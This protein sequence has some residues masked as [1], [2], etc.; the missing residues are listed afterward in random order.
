MVNGFSHMRRSSILV[1]LSV[2]ILLCTLAY[3]YLYPGSLALFEGR[4]DT[5]MSDGTDPTGLSYVYDLIIDLWRT[6]PARY[7]YGALFTNV[8]DPEYGNIL[9]M[10]LSERW[11]VLLHSNFFALEQL[12]TAYVYTLLVLNGL[13]MFALSLYMGWSQWIATGLAIAWAFNTFTMARA[14]VHM[15]M[16]GI[17]H[18]PLIFL[19]LMMVVRGK[20]K[21]SL[22]WASLALL[23]A[24]TTVHYF[25][26]ISLFLSPFFVLFVLIQPEF[27]SDW[28]RIGKRFTIAVVPVLLLLGMNYF[29]ALPPETRMT[30]S[31]SMTLDVIPDGRTHPYLRTYSA[32]PI[33]YL[34]GNLFG[35]DGSE[36]N[37]LRT[38]I[39]DHILGNLEDSNSHERTNGIRWSV[40]ALGLCAFACLFMGK[41]KEQKVVS[42]NL[43]YFFIFGLFAFWL[44][45]SP[46]VPF[47]ETGPSYWLHR[48]MPKV[49]VLNRAGVYVH[50]ALLMAVGFLLS[51]KFKWRKLLAAFPL[52][53]VVDYTP[54]MAMPM[55]PIYP[56]YEALQREKGECGVG[57]QIPF[58]NPYS[59]PL[60]SYLFSQRLR[61]SDCL[62]LNI[63][64]SKDRLVWLWSQF[65][66]TSEFVTKVSQSPEILNRLDKLVSCVPLSWIIF[67]PAID[68]RIGAQVCQRLGWNYHS[69]QTC[70]APATF[71]RKYQ[72]PPESCGL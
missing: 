55:A 38:L 64:L 62:P 24:A 12:S 11:L 63:S 67:H 30:S 25:L 17:Y 46:D 57:I 50:F 71:A 66:A 49:R 44:S 52:L 68:P 59:T 58:I 33:D 1:F 18:L 31:E 3:F 29:F 4:T 23:F 60:D 37:P 54:M 19:G 5:F 35:T 72:R 65:P 43:L 28:K 42:R 20:S 70:V 47:F 27:K 10:P 45:L 13:C 61:G 2:F 39:N 7:F 56:R 15:G 41:F 22:A 32:R 21:S 34:G 51:T 53:M 8:G 16:A 6:Y 40:L 14:K 9:W 36:L 48:I 69:D 26:I